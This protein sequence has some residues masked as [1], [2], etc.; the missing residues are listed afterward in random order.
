MNIFYITLS[1]NET[2][3]IVDRFD[4]KEWVLCVK[5]TRYVVYSFL[6]SFTNAWIRFAQKAI[7]CQKR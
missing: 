5:E 6:I 1:V 2:L 7:V 4:K 3:L